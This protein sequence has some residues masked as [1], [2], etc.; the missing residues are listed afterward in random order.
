[1][2]FRLKMIHISCINHIYDS[3]G[4]TI[5]TNGTL[6]QG[7]KR[8]LEL[9]PTITDNLYSDRVIS[10][11]SVGISFQAA[12]TNATNGVMTFGGVDSSR[13]IGDVIY[14]APGLVSATF[15]LYIP[16]KKKFAH[17]I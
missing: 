10:S 16:M 2:F 7:H 15:V 12:D 9:V 1:M 11:K 3:V 14:A 4:P 13:Y 6:R 8:I 17:L 5:L